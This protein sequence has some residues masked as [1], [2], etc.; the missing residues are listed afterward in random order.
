MF[1]FCLQVIASGIALK[2]LTHC[3]RSLH[4]LLQ[5]WDI[6]HDFLGVH[7]R[8]THL[9]Q[10]L[11]IQVT[12]VVKVLVAELLEHVDVLLAHTRANEC[13][14]PSGHW[15]THRD[16]NCVF[17]LVLV[18][19]LPNDSNKICIPFVKASTFSIQTRRPRKKS[20]LSKT[21]QSRVVVT[22]SLNFIIT[23]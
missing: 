4:R 18:R 14:Q 20:N 23:L 3:G 11:R 15:S 12:H 16:R 19:T 1:T 9:Q 13:L 7:S 5:N 21:E 8:D 17:V 2:A 22:I 10:L 6:L